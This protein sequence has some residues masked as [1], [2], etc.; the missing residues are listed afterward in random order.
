MTD[1]RTLLRVAFVIKSPDGVQRH[2]VAW[3]D[4]LPDDHPNDHGRG[5]ETFRLSIREGDELKQ[6][7]LVLPS[8]LFV[9][10]HL[11]RHLHQILDTVDYGSKETA[12]EVVEIIEDT[13]RVIEHHFCHCQYC[14]S[15]FLEHFGYLGAVIKKCK[16]GRLTVCRGEVGRPKRF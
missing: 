8:L 14:G 10:D 1:I 9:K 3:V 16:C 6:E 5:L 7:K 12:L 15:I 4:R 11:S 13:H 2:V